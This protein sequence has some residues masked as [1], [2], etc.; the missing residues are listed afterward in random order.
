MART[1]SMIE[2]ASEFIRLRESEQPEQQHRATHDFVSDDVWFEVLRER[3]DLAE[4]VAVNK[5]VSLTMLRHLAISPDVRVRYS[6]AMKRK[7]DGQLFDLLSRDEDESVRS[8]IAWNRKAPLPILE[9]LS[10]DESPLVAKAA[11]ERL[12]ARRGGQ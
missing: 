9:R 4:W 3:P 6:V 5:T 7:L 1:D 12:S 10:V 8:C 11:Q 2:S